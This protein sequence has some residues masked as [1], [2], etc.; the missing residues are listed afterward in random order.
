MTPQ[1]N[2]RLHHFLTQLVSVQ[3]MPKDQEAQALINA[4]VARQPDAAY[5]LVQRAL[6]LEQGLDAARAQIAE[7]QERLQA[8]SQRGASGGF[9]S[10]ENAWGNS[11][12]TAPGNPRPAQAAY[13]QPPAAAPA[14]Q[15]GLPSAPYYQRQGGWANAGGSGSFLGTMAATAAGV[16]GGAFLFHGLE[17]MFSHHD[18][19]TQGSHFGDTAGMNA[20]P[21]AGVRDSSLAQDAGINDIGQ[22]GLSGSDERVAQDE[23][24]GLLDDPGVQDNYAGNDDLAS[25]DDYGVSDD[26]SLI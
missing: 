5:L 23:R 26:D 18:A 22:A 10:D 9:L 11:A 15:P 16:A 2:E 17:N 20:I 19:P 13:P 4:A 14:Y 24:A 1:E 21:D 3:N 7:L 6:I 25:S 12:R 8:G